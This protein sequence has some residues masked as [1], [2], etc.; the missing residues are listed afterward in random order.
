MYNACSLG[1][2]VLM[3]RNDSHQDTRRLG[4]GMVAAA[5]VLAIILLTWFFSGVE[6]RSRNPNSNPSWAL[7][8][9]G[10]IAVVLERNRA[11]HYVMTGSINGVETEFLLDTGATDVVIPAALADAAGLQ[12]RQSGQAM[13]ANGLVTVYGT[14]IDN[15]ALGPITLRDVRAS[16]NPAMHDSMVLLGMS[17]LRQVEFSQRG[18]ELTLRYHPN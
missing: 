15:L 1:D 6:E 4:Q 2:A 8:E 12:A 17:A 7:A 13:T 14:R 10:A 3:S 11:G 9:G 5:F 18:A 16:I